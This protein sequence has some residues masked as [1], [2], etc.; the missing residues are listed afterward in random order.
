LKLPVF[1]NSSALSAIGA[2]NSCSRVEE[3]TTGVR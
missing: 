2:P 1:W 3:V